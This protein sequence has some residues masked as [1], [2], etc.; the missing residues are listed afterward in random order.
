MS[1][2]VTSHEAAQSNHHPQLQQHPVAWVATATAVYTLLAAPNCTASELAVAAAASSALTTEYQQQQEQ[3]QQQHQQQVAI[4]PGLVASPL[5]NEA[6]ADLT[7]AVTQQVVEAA[8]QQVVDAALSPGNSLEPSAA[9]LLAASSAGPQ[10]PLLQ[11]SQPSQ[12]QQS[13]QQQ[14]QSKQQQQQQQAF[15][16][17]LEEDA[18]VM[19]EGLKAVVGEGIQQANL[20]EGTLEGTVP[21]GRW[22]GVGCGAQGALLG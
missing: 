10:P 11:P 3:Q 18:A 5:D 14:Q 15:Q 7:A 6:T 13:E 16:Q 9:A 19:V 4:A 20:M 22:V 8:A 12:Q 2:S 17:Q 1:S 21:G